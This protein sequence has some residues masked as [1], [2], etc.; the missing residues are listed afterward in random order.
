[1]WQKFLATKDSKWNFS[2]SLPVTAGN[3]LPLVFLLPQPSSSLLPFKV[4]ELKFINFKSR[5]I[6]YRSRDKNC[7]GEEKKIACLASLE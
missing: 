6:R 2:I 5:G 4:G 1:M 3:F 7:G